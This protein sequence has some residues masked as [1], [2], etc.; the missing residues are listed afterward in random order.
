MHIYFLSCR[1]GNTV[2]FRIVNII[3]LKILPL[4]PA[5]AIRGKK[6]ETEYNY[7]RRIGPLKYE[8][9]YSMKGVGHLARP[10]PLLEGKGD[11]FGPYLWAIGALSGNSIYRGD[12]TLERPHLVLF[13][14]M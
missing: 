12:M 6:E 10:A 9:L 14:D 5:I 8:Y 1:K 2:H 4:K 3:A 13:F 11:I 7:T